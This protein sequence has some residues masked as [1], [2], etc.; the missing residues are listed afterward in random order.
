MNKPT[1][2]KVAVILFALSSLLS[3]IVSLPGVIDPNISDGIP[4][5][6]IALGAILGAA[7]LVSAWG[8]W[9][10]Q[11]WA[12]WLTIFICVVGGLSALPGLLFAP[13]NIARVGA[14]AGVAIPIF[15]IAVFLLYRPTV[16][17]S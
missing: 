16:S 2:F 7:G 15:V 12:I 14:I 4:P 5:F 6:V 17:Q 3:I 1:L 13:N 9:R 8:A 10:G 11:K